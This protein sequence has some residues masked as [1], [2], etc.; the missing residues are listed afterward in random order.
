MVYGIVKNHNGRIDVES[1]PGRGTTF[2]LYLPTLRLEKKAAVDEITREVPLGGQNGD[3]RGTVLIAEDEERMVQLLRK[4]LL[5]AGYQVMAATDGQQAIDLYQNHKK[6]IDIVLVDLGLPKASGSEVI[7][8]LKKHN[9][10][11]TIIVATGYLE[12]ELKSDL[13][14]AGVKDYVQKPYRLNDVLEKLRS[15]MDRS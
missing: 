3:H 5:Q 10:L 13:L 15:I 1:E 12:P 7:R 8:A 4:V 6:D 14:R 2:R 11:V 9:P